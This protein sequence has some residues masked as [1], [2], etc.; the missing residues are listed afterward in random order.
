MCARIKKLFKCGFVHLARVL[1][2]CFLPISAVGEQCYGDL[3]FV[4]L[5]WES[6]MERINVICGF[7]TN[8]P[9]CT[10]TWA[11]CKSGFQF[12]PEPPFEQSLCH[13][14][15]EETGS[16]CEYNTCWP[17]V[18]YFSGV[19]YC[20]PQSPSPGCDS[21]CADWDTERST[22]ASYYWREDLT[23]PCD[24]GA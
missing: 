20:N 23:V 1:L 4:E 14:L 2:A 9:L 6:G 19:G 5:G 13:Q 21:G 24:D 15:Q 11:E 8:E 3:Y 10:V 7:Q 17:I 16:R 18:T 22:D 12:D